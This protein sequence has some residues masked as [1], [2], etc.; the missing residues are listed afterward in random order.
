MSFE[1]IKAKVSSGVDL[2]K[3]LCRSYVNTYLLKSDRDKIRSR[4]S[5]KYT[6]PP[7]PS[8]SGRPI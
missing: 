7:Y 1:V 5:K 8:A 3:E 2:Q 6:I 4:E